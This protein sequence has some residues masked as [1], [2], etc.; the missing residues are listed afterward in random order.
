MTKVLSHIASKCQSCNW[1]GEPQDMWCSVDKSHKVEQMF[2]FYDADAPRGSKY[3]YSK[4]PSV[5]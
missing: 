3:S 5:A 1:S 2:V 4:S